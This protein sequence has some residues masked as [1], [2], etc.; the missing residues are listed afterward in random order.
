[1]AL[2][3]HPLQVPDDQSLVELLL[4]VGELELVDHVDRGAAQVLAHG[5]EVLAVEEGVVGAPEGQGL[6]GD[7]RVGDPGAAQVAA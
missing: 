6:G 2:A 1:V 4:V 3:S 7:V 5:G